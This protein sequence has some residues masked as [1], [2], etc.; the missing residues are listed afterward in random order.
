MGRLTS[1]V[2]R[3]LGDETRRDCCFLLMARV[4][5]SFLPFFVCFFL[6]FF[7]EGRASRRG[8][9]NLSPGNGSEWIGSDQTR[10]DG[11]R[12]GSS[13][14][15][16]AV[17]LRCVALRCAKRM[18]VSEPFR[19]WVWMGKTTLQRQRIVLLKK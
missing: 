8:M 3:S 17:A 15:E 16:M 7:R 13:E 10:C 19:G 9:L 12:W 1:P 18:P 6:P 2:G 5:P 11:L 4:V 14:A